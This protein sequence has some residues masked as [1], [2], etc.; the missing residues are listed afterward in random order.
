[1]DT[2]NYTKITND[3]LIIN[4]LLTK[5]INTKKIIFFLKSFNFILPSAF[6]KFNNFN[7]NRTNREYIVYCGI[8]GLFS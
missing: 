4:V 7:S 2:K 6:I 5:F 8:V 1:M 3:C